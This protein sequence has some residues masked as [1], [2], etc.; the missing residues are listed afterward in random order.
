MRIIINLSISLSRSRLSSL[1]PSSLLF[2]PSRTK[3]EGKDKWQI[4]SLKEQ[5]Q[6]TKKGHETAD[7]IRITF[8]ILVLLIQLLAKVFPL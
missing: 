4:D 8:Y 2:L 3:E 5:E 1:F 7:K 6:E